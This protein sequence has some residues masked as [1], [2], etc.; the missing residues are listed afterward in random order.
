MNRARFAVLASTLAVFSASCASAPTPQ[1]TG[2]AAQKPAPV[3]VQ[4][5]APAPREPS[6]L[7]SVMAPDKLPA[8]LAID[9]DVAEWGSLLPPPPPPPRPPPKVAKGKTPPPPPPPPP[10]D[11][12]P[13]DAPSHLAFALTKDGA[14]VAADLTERAKEGIWLA[15]G[16]QPSPLPSIGE[17][18]RGGG[19]NAFNCETDPSGEPLPPETAQ[20]CLG[21]LARHEAFVQAH[22]ARFERVFRLDKRGLWWVGQGG[23]IEP[24]PNSVAAMKMTERGMTIEARIPLAAYP[25]ASVVP[26]TGAFVQAIAATTPTPPKVEGEKWI[27]VAAPEALLLEPYAELREAV[28]SKGFARI[29]PLGFSY[30]PADPNRVE[31]VRHPGGWNA[32]FVEAT[33]APLYVPERKLGDLEVGYASV[34]SPAVAIFKAGK[35]VDLVDIVGEPMGSV[36]RNKQIHVFS[37]IQGEDEDAP[38]L[39]SQWSVLAVGEDGSSGNPINTDTGVFRWTQV[40]EIHSDKFDWFGVR[41]VPHGFADEETPRP[42]EILWRFDKQLEGYMPTT[43]PLTTLPAQRPRKKKP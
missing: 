13:R 41:G 6:S 18:Q 9:G 29:H 2:K 27:E 11:P 15:F 36:E 1:N 17:L 42:V 35:F 33:E 20:S 26:L 4:V 34:A 32:S 19:I 7:V 8:N 3:V 40:Y 39:G 28:Y 21:L 38:G 31:T 5:P 24:V 16:F 43:R 37:Y 10:P 12:N 30:H 23:A 14:F 25:R 22:E